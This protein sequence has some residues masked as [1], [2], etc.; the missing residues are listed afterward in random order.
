MNSIKA[1]TCISVI[2]LVGILFSGYLTFTELTAGKCPVSGCQSIFGMPTCF[3]G[4]IM[5][6]IVLV[7]SI[8]GRKN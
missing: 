2:S 7:I 5:Y 6:L 1:L 3:Y 8:L 4:L